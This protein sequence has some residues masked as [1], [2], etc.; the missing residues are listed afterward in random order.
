[1]PVDGHYDASKVFDCNTDVDVNA[2]RTVPTG[3]YYCGLKDS[4]NPN[5]SAM[6]PDTFN[7]KWKKCDK[8]EGCDAYLPI[9]KDYRYPAYCDVPYK[10]NDNANSTYAK[11]TYATIKETTGYDENN[12]KEFCE[13]N[14]Y[15][16]DSDYFTGHKYLTTVPK[17][18]DG[19]APATQKDTGGQRVN[20]CNSDTARQQASKYPGDYGK[21]IQ[22]Q[23][24]YTQT[25]WDLGDGEQTVCCTK[26]DSNKVC[27]E[28][29]KNVVKDTG[30]SGW[31]PHY[32]DQGNYYR[33]GYCAYNGTSGNILGPGVDVLS[34]NARGDSARPNLCCGRVYQGNNYYFPK[35]RLPNYLKKYT[36]YNYQV[37]AV[38][39]DQRTG[40]DG[41]VYMNTYNPSK[42]AGYTPY[43]PGKGTGV[44]Q[45]YNQKPENAAAPAYVPYDGNF[46]KSGT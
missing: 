45:W 13:N 28:L 24:P 19:L 3:V 23:H 39:E 36:G 20:L 40:T 44:G 31:Y 8:K 35:N 34:G 5:W 27:D 30:D 33:G 17:N 29:M 11:S 43:K 14:V 41:K 9:S 2:T 1:M 38:P 21:T 42:D 6:N 18:S 12:K 10:D 37:S 32:Y 7:A 16:G 46:T 26:V 25:M 4:D 22:H 15:Q